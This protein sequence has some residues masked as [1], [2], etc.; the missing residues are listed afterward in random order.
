MGYAVQDARAL[1]EAKPDDNLA[2][3]GARNVEIFARLAQADS[4][5]CHVIPVPRAD[6]IRSRWSTS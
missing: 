1:V 2:P 3:G 6:V 5:G 4:W